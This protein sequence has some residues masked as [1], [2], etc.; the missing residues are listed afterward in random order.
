MHNSVVACCHT[1]IIATISVQKTAASASFEQ[2]IYTGF[3]PQLQ[4]LA[5][6]AHTVC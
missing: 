6:R 4:T 1:V 3:C 2:C 5:P